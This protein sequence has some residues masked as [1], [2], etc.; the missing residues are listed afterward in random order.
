[1]IGCSETRSV[2]AQPVRALHVNTPTGVQFRSVHVLRT[3]LESRA[4]ESGYKLTQLHDALLVTRVGVTKLIGCS[5]RSAS[6]VQLIICYE[7]T[8]TQP[9][10]LQPAI[11]FVTCRERM[12]GSVNIRRDNKQ[13]RTAAGEGGRTE[14]ER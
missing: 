9:R 4:V 8:S 2:G 3:G 1:M 14:P 5:S 12:S 7:R 10:L 11:N 13:K 6:S